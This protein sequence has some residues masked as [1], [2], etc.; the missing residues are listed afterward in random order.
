MISNMQ[1][2]KDSLEKENKPKFQSHTIAGLVILFYKNL[3]GLS[4]YRVTTALMLCRALARRYKKM[5]FIKELDHINSQTNIGYPL[6]LV[7]TI[8]Y[9][10]TMLGW[11]INKSY[12]YGRNKRTV[13][14]GEL[15]LALDYSLSRVLEIFTTI[16][17]DEDIDVEVALPMNAGVQ[18]DREGL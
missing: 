9:R 6:G 13:R 11:K 17:V 16:C 10:D 1:E 15:I 4:P 14:L 3:S 18:M 8:V 7:Q 2:K 12:N 5:D